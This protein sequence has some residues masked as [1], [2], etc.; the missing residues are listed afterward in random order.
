MVDVAAPKGRTPREQ[1]GPNV[2]FARISD[3]AI[4][5]LEAGAA[6]LGMSR[7]AYTELFIRRAPLDEHGLPA[8]AREEFTGEQ[9][10]LLPRLEEWVQRLRQLREEHQ[11]SAA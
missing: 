10:E 6:A 4:S 1:S 3:E 7:S 8:W 9:L 11:Q 5:I 2:L